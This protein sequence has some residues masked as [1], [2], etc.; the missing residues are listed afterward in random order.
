[1]FCS[2]SLLPILACRL[3][4]RI[5]VLTRPKRCCAC[6]RVIPVMWAGCCLPTNECTKFLNI[7]H[8]KRREEEGLLLLFFS[9]DVDVNYLS[10]G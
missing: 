7:T 1:M 9:P 2:P 8:R 6:C 4:W 10:K 5:A 3:H